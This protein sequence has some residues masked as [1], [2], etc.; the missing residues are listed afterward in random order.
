MKIAITH[1]SRGFAAV[2]SALAVSLCTAAGAAATTTA[3]WAGA[4][5]N[6]N[7]STAANWG[8]GGAP[9]GSVDV[10][11]LPA[12]GSSCVGWA[13]SY[14]VDDIPALT[15]GSLEMD[16]SA[17]YLVAPMSSGDSLALTGG[18]TFGTNSQESGGRLLTTMIV[19]LSLGAAQSW[20][21]NGVP[22][23]PTQLTLGAITGEPYPLT[24]DLADGVALQAPEL[25]TGPLTIS[26]AGIVSLAGQTATP[27]DGTP[28][29]PPP[30]IGP[31]GVALANGASLVFN[32]PG[33]VSGPISVAR[34]SYTTIE[35]G[36]GVAPDGTVV[37]NGNVTLRAT[38]TLAQWIDQPAVA[39]RTA[40][41]GHAIPARPQPSSDY[42]Q[43]VALG[44]VA[45]NGAGLNL[46]QGY[47]DTQVSCATMTG[48]QT[49]TLL[50]ATQLTG[51]FA[52]VANGQVV[53][54]GAC[55][56]A[57][58]GPSYA[59]IIAYNTTRRPETVTATIVGPAQIRSEVTRALAVS[60]VTSLFTVL[61]R[62]GYTATFN[63]PAD[64]TLA[65]TWR[66]RVRGRLVTVASGSNTAGQVGPRRV[67]IKLT[68]A[69]RALLRRSASVTLTATADFTPT[70]QSAVIV[71]RPIRLG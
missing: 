32:S 6:V 51:T 27:A 28:V 23:T 19:P 2:A 3:A 39:A 66:A 57:A 41:P 61:S 13:C 56:P 58:T 7:W 12:S 70:G 49:Y 4:G 36:H 10:L 53:P 9:S 24:V 37:V 33:T 35:V 31:Q 45:L 69:G 18:L 46:A 22:G 48:G 38:S 16:S 30:L 26:G 11:M 55:N 62:G 25:D 59:V 34:G 60:A 42:S 1:R 64:G 68:A 15:V 47:S 17:D 14:A 44:D 29:N 20:S 65:L 43:L 50:S 63:A 67:P 40:R 8:A 52:G 5:S 21:V 54:L 71:S